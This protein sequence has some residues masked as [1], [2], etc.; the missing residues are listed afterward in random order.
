MFPD[1]EP[2]VVKQCPCWKDKVKELLRIIKTLPLKNR[3]AFF[4]DRPFTIAYFV[5]P[6]G[7]KKITN[8]LF[9]EFLVVKI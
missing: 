9:I 1:G 2:T 7:R 4:K 3:R 8:I 5:L 6:R